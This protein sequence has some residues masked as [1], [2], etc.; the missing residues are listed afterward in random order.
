M[1]RHAATNSSTLSEHEVDDLFGPEDSNSKKSMKITRSGDV[2]FGEAKILAFPVRS[3]RGSFAYVTCPQILTRFARESNI[4]DLPDLPSPEEQSCFAAS[5]VTFAD[6]KAVVLE[7]YKFTHEGPFPN[8]WVSAIRDLVDD[9]VWKLAPE[10]LVLLSD[11][12]F[13]HAVSTMTEI[14]HHTKIDAATGTVAKGA[15]FNLESIPA[16]SLFMATANIIGHS[17][18]HA[19]R[20]PSSDQQEIYTTDTTR[21]PQQTSRSPPTHPTGGELDY[22][23]W[24]LHSHFSLIHAMKN[25]EQIRAKNSLA[26]ASRVASGTEIASGKDGGDAIKKIPAMIIANGLL[27]TLAFSVERKNKTREFQRA[28]YAAIMGAIAC[29]LA[30]PDVGILDKTKDAESMLNHLA[31]SDSSSLRLATAEALA[32]L[33]YA[34]R[35]ITPADENQ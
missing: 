33:G 18:S 9:P 22:R 2:S 13:S 16:E 26:L 4:Q 27:A 30:D 10:R 15:L 17:K 7:E 14:S 5:A 31:A 19:Q 21:E 23:P 34:R 6:K 28:G 29:H 1:L 25:L 3:A 8:E 35:F 24:F 12:D 32:W 11:G 20:D